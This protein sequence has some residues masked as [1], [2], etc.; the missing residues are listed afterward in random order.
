AL[1]DVESKLDEVV[2]ALGNLGALHNAVGALAMPLWILVALVTAL[3][4]RL[5]HW[6]RDDR[7]HAGGCS[8]SAGLRWRPK[9]SPSL[10]RTTRLPV[11]RAALTPSA[12]SASHGVCGKCAGRSPLRCHRSTTSAG[13]R[14]DARP[15]E[16]HRSA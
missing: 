15:H 6:W 2:Q 14:G 16:P 4:A 13:P 3:L 7:P 10:P 11:P 5:L 8:Y 1:G 12:R 9:L